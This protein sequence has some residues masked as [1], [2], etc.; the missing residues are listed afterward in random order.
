MLF[1][2]Q[3]ADPGRLGIK[4]EMRKGAVAMH[5]ACLPRLLRHKQMEEPVEEPLV[6]YQAH[7]LT[8]AGAPAQ[9]RGYQ[10]R[11]HLHLLVMLKAHAPPCALGAPDEFEPRKASRQLGSGQLGPR[12]E[13]SDPLLVQIHPHLRESYAGRVPDQLGR[14]ERASRRA[15]MD[16]VEA[17]A[18]GKAT[19]DPL[20][21]ARPVAAQA[22]IAVGGVQHT[23]IQG[24]AVPHQE[25]VHAT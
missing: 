16:P 19:C 24:L 23:C 7:A 11:A 2:A 22:R 15:R 8:G 9:R 18:R 21:L 17:R 3:R 13:G 25:K 14:L 5:V 1:A 10:G 6:A 12:R 4:H 20:R